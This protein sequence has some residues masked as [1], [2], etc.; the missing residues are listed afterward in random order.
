[1]KD[2]DAIIETVERNKP[3]WFVLGRDNAISLFYENGQ[4]NTIYAPWCESRGCR[5]IGAKVKKLK[6]PDMV[7]WI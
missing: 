5:L 2:A 7:F 3:D 4:A 1:M 6:D